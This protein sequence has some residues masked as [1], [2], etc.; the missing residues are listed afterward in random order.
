METNMLK[1]W[2]IS[3]A[4]AIGASGVV[5]AQDCKPSKWGANDEIG[6]ANYI[7]PQSV[8]AATKLVKMGQTH[9]LG[10]VV[11]P[12]MPAFPPRSVSLQI[13]SPGQHN[14][15]DLTKDFGWPAVY[16]DDL[17]QLWF[18]V[19]PQL[20]GLGHL[21]E[22]NLYYN[23]NHAFD[24]VTLTGLTKLGTDKVPPMVARG[25]LIDMAKHF[26]VESMAP[27][28]A[29]TPADI[30]AAMKAQGV[31]IRQGDVVLFH[32]GYTDAKLKSDPKT[33]VSTQPGL[34]NAAAVHLAKMNPMA[35]GADTWG[36]EAV[37]PAPGDR[38]FYGHVTFLKEHGIYILETMNTG[39]LAKESVKEFMFVLGQAR[40]KGA[41]QMMINPVAMW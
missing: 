28:Q 26:K 41:V 34:T 1:K 12:G 25:V 4:F 33:W 27:G 30:D 6:A 15:R 16:N 8:L 13:V 39:R 18:G 11:E 35:V 40:V 31:Q 3:A 2:L 19:G 10:I 24:F 7:T 23:C 5:L 20:D 38:V 14:G 37:P 32:T 22:K 9:P 17:A 29:I 21:G 36:L